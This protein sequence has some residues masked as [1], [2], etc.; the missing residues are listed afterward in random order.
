MIWDESDDTG[1]CLPPE[2][3]DFDL[4]EQVTLGANDLLEV[5]DS[6][7]NHYRKVISIRNKYSNIYDGEV[8]SV[9]M[10][11]S[12]IFALQYVDG[13]NDDEVL[14]VHNFSESEQTITIDTNLEIVDNVVVQG[15]NARKTNSTLIISPF[16]TV[17]LQ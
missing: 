8:S 16:S 15:K 6:L 17:I 5:A 12:A 11:N 14:V 2:G 4:E 13:T 7:T 9:D 3:Y 1:L 10:G